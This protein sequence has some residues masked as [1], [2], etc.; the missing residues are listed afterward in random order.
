MSAQISIILLGSGFLAACMYSFWAV[1]KH[2][3]YGHSDTFVSILFVTIMMILVSAFDS[4]PKQLLENSLYGETLI[5][6]TIEEAVKVSGLLM[7]ASI[8]VSPNT[9]LKVTVRNPVWIL[10][11]VIA[12]Y[13]NILI[14]FGPLFSS[15]E[16]A[17]IAGEVGL[18]NSPAINYFASSGLLA[19]T[20]IGALRYF[21]HFYLTALAIQLW[22]NKQFIL[23]TSVMVL[24]GVINVLSLAISINSYSAKE[25]TIINALLFAASTV[26]LVAI[27]NFVRSKKSQLDFSFSPD[28]SINTSENSK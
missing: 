3:Q 27:T 12:T 7:F 24:H 2:C 17:I 13:E 4:D 20:A 5:R 9:N 22:K 21:I 6:G 16:V 10:A 26:A 19:L 14:C 25:D 28:Y 15:I 11:V 23:V 1:I 8:H 18:Q